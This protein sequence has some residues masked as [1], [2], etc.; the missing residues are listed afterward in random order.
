[1]AVEIKRFYEKYKGAV[2]VLGLMA[3][4]IAFSETLIARQTKTRMYHISG[5]CENSVFSVGKGAIVSFD[6][7]TT[8]SVD[9]GLTVRR[10]SRGSY[11][12][13]VDIHDSHFEPTYVVDWNV[14]EEYHPNEYEVSQML[15]YQVHG[16]AYSGIKM[17]RNVA[18]GFNVEVTCNRISRKAE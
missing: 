10:V 6:S 11:A 7:L 17:I 15:P 4:G 14:D 8:I 12:D 9:D 5:A 18:G 16:Y 1:M 13:V 3:L 2:W